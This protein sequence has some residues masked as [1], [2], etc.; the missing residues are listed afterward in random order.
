[1]RSSASALLDESVDAN[2]L[3]LLR[4][5]LDGALLATE[6]YHDLRTRGS[7]ARIF[8]EIHLVVRSDLS[9]LEAHDRCDALEAALEDR[10]PRAELTV[11]VEPDVAPHS[12]PRLPTK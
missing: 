3:A 4:R 9:V 10:M 7:G 8:V 2:E 5:T 12:G 1:M 11:H 6:S